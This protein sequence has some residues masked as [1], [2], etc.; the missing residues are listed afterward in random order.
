METFVVIAFN[1]D[2]F[3]PVAVADNLAIAINYAN[4]EYKE[5]AKSHSIYVYKKIMN[6]PQTLEDKIVYKL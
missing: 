2:N 3:Y 1:K 6:A 4:M 5:R